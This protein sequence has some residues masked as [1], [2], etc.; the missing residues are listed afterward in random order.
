MSTLSDNFGQLLVEG[1]AKAHMPNHAPFKESEWPDALCAVN[2]LVGYEK[3]A[4]LN[5]FLQRPDGREGDDGAH[6]NVS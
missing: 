1:V 6:T 5:L 2:D 4:R 3:V